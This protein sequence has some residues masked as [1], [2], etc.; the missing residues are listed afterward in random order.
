MTSLA[1]QPRL[2]ATIV[3]HPSSGRLISMNEVV[4]VLSCD[5]TWTERIPVM[6]TQNEIVSPVVPDVTTEKQPDSLTPNGDECAAVSENAPPEGYEGTP[7]ELW[8]DK[9]GNPPVIT[10]RLL[11]SLRG[12]YF[13]VRHV[14][15]GNCGHLLDMI[16]QPK[17]NCHECWVAFFSTHPQ[18]VEVAHQFY[19]T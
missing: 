8:P 1:S 7:P 13:T 12:K 14:R 2:S 16:N 6:D 17:N 5:I 19:Q 9:D 15:L 4:I 18:L 3:G 11:K 10:E